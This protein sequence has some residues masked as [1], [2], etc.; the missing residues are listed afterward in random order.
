MSRINGLG[1]TFPYEED[2][3]EAPYSDGIVSS[4]NLGTSIFMGVPN[5]TAIYQTKD[6]QP[7][8]VKHYLN[9]TDCVDAN[10]WGFPVLAGDGT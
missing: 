5:G 9:G 3:I 2:A 7:G 8:S 6:F 1:G 4:S 10:T